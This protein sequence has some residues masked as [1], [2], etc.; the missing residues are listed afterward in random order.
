[1]RIRGRFRPCP[2]RNAGATSSPASCAANAA[3]G[4]GS[5]SFSPRLTHFQDAPIA[6]RA[7]A[8]YVGVVT[9]SLTAALVT[10]RDR[11]CSFT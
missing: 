11:T 7:S 3:C 5:S 1:M 2:A 8:F 6:R 9:Y 4:P 10:G